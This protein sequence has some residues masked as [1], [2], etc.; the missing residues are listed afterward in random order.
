VGC[1]TA[2]VDQHQSRD[3]LGALERQPARCVAADRVADD[4]DVAQVQ[5]VGEFDE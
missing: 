3:P 4:D 5:S 2:G 1:E